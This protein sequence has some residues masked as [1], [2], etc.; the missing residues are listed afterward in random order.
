MSRFRL[1]ISIRRR[2]EFERLFRS[3]RVDVGGEGN[4]SRVRLFQGSFVL[5]LELASFSRDRFLQGGTIERGMS[6]SAMRSFMLESEESTQTHF[7]SH[8]VVLLSYSVSS[9]KYRR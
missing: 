4:G 2:E 9:Q 1:D 8:S 6:K 3:R 5:E 7:S